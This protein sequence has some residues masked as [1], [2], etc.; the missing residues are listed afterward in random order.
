M[1]ASGPQIGNFTLIS[2]QIYQLP[3][4]REGILRG[5]VNKPSF[6][7]KILFCLKVNI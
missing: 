6:E 1:V 2:A 5:E 7:V 4:K 3:Q